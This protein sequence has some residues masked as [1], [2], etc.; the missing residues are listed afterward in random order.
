MLKCALALLAAK[1]KMQS[2]SLK[3]CSEVSMCQN[4]KCYKMCLGAPSCQTENAISMLKCALALL[5]V[6]P[7]MQS[8]SLIMFSDVSICVYAFAVDVCICMYSKT[9]NYRGAPNNRGAPQG[10]RLL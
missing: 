9:L 2:L 5:V 10:R 7:K 4:Q 6:K 1:L 3:M 8:L